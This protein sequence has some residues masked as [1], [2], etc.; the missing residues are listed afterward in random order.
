MRRR[1]R[2]P[3]DGAAGPT[4]STEARQPHTPPRNVNRRGTREKKK[5]ILRNEAACAAAA[6]AVVLCVPLRR[7]RGMAWRPAMT[8]CVVI[9]LLGLCTVATAA[10]GT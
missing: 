10:A 2:T 9:A 4:V 8:T 1:E 7:I 6:S 5:Y 3:P